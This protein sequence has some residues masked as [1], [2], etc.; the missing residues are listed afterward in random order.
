MIYS[1]VV[2]VAIIAGLNYAAPPTQIPPAPSKKQAIFKIGAKKPHCSAFVIDATHAL[3]A[4][5]CVVTSGVFFDLPMP[6]INAFNDDDTVMKS[7]LV[8]TH[9]RDPRIDLALLTGDFSDHLNLTHDPRGI[10]LDKEDQFIACGF[11]YVTKE[12]VCS[13]IKPYENYGPMYKAQGYIVFGFSGG[14]V[15][16]ITK[17]LVVGV[18]TALTDDFIVITPI[19]GIR[20]FFSLP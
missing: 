18:N 6:T 17:G 4:E 5:H 11:P 16:N 1:T 15:I 19:T 10:H 13:K 3:T 9:A 12:L 14:P 8:V 7:G 2:A 20:G